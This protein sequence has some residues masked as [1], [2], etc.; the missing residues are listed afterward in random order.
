MQGDLVV[1]AFTGGAFGENGYLL[2]CAGGDAAFLVDPGAAVG[3]MLRA[4]REGAEVVISVR[5]SGIGIAPSDMAA[6]FGMF[7]Q[8]ESTIEKSN[9][10]LG[11]G[12]WLV[13]RLVD[14]H[15]GSVS[16]YSEGPGHGCTFTV[17]LPVAG[18][19]GTAA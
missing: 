14:L 16:A 13:K 9:G 19:T 11:I 2:S 7:V 17:R 8:V 1:R 4:V 5:D 18:P 10:G 15:G 12:L 3:E 6:V